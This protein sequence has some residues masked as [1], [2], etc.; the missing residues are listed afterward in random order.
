MKHVGVR[1]CGWNV[2]RFAIVT[3]AMTIVAHA[4]AYLTHEY[5]HSSMAW[6]LGWMKT[7]FAIDYGS[8]TPNNVIFLDDVS[9]NVDYGPILANG[10]GYS[11]AVIALA[12]PFIGNGALFFLLDRLL[13]TKVVR[14]QWLLHAFLYWLCLMCA[15]N[16]WGYVPI[17]AITTHADIALAAQGLGLSPWALFPAL[18]TLSGYIVFRFFTKTFPRACDG[19]CGRNPEKYLLL[20]VLSAFWFFSFFSADGISGSYGVLSQILSIASRYLVFPLCAVWLW[21]AYGKDL[22][23]RTPASS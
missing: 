14:S 21:N 4:L 6:L 18:M 19:I 22:S 16:V 10:K 3:F 11:V 15:G 7:P 12:G 23:S 20:S 9:D 5:S 13:R 17:R 8:A 1:D 2:V